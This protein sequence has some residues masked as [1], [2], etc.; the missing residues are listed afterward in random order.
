MK[1]I[2]TSGLELNEKQ[3]YPIGWGCRIHQLYRGNPPT[4][5]VLDMTLNNLMVRFQQCRILGNVEYSFIAIA[6][7]STLAQSGS[8]C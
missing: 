3:Y 5:S 6:P 4:K 8:I 7:K 1:K 2:L